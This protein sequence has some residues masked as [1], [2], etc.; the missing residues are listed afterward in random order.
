MPT[1][2]V[3]VWNIQDFGDNALKRRGDYAP[4]CSFIARVARIVNADIVALMELRPA[5]VARLD[6]LR[7]ALSA[8][9]PIGQRNWYFDWIK[10]AIN[11]NDNSG[12]NTNVTTSAQLDW[13]GNANLEGYALF[14]NDDPNKF[15]MQQA[16]TTLSNGVGPAPLPLVVPTHCL[17][18]ALEGRPPAGP[19]QG[20]YTAPGFDA[21][22]NAIPPGTI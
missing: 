12:A 22:N 21:A 1:I 6:M 11:T 8:A 19:A 13:D 9:W 20:W 18:L 3:L 2:N 16:P 15:A 7:A 14:W 4:L 5:G 17:S 10:G